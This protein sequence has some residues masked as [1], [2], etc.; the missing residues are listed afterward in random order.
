MKKLSL[1]AAAALV[2]SAAANGGAAEAKTSL[3]LNLGNLYV[4]NSD[5]TKSGQVANLQRFLGEVGYLNA[6]ATG[7]FGVMTQDAVK[8]FQGDYELEQTGYV[9]PATS[10]KIEEI[11]CGTKAVASKPVNGDLATDLSLYDKIK[12]TVKRKG[13]IDIDGGASYAIEAKAGN[14]KAN[15]GYWIMSADCEDDVEVSFK[16][17]GDCYEDTGQ[18]SSTAKAYGNM[19]GYSA[20]IKNEGDEKSSVTITATAYTPSGQMIGSKGKRLSV[21]VGPQGY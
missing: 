6:A 18:I 20:Y 19:T 14:K 5:A 17:G 21:P 15:V 10:L 3:C 4:G 13:A 11:G 1:L 9:G 7:Y 8:R 12:L 16:V 2:L